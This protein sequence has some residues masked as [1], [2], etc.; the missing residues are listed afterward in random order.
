MKA[1]TD[2]TDISN[3]NNSKNGGTKLIYFFRD[4]WYN[5]LAFI[6]KWALSI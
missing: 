3:K 5:E 1:L 4:I 6:L 2:N